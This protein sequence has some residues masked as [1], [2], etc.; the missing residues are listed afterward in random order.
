M[1]NFIKA[2]ALIAAVVFFTHAMSGVGRAQSSE[3]VVNPQVP[4]WEYWLCVRRTD[5]PDA[6]ADNDPIMI[7]RIRVIDACARDNIKKLITDLQMYQCMKKA[8]D[9]A[10][11]R[12]TVLQKWGPT[13][14]ALPPPAPGMCISDKGM[15]PCK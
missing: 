8:N 6:M 4:A 1:P 2:T 7:D 3:C 12:L 10:I 13:I 14:R 9:V 15:V 11:N 5:L